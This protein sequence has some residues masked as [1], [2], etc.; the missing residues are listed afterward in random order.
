MPRL[1]RSPD[2]RYIFTNGFQLQMTSNEVTL[3]LCIAEDAADSEN[4]L[5]EMVGAVMTPTAAKLLASLLTETLAN[6]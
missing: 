5:L 4:S 1:N 3:R 2:F 6:F